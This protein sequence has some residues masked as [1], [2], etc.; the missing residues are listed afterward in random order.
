MGFDTNDPGVN[1][2]QENDLDT[3]FSE[4]NAVYG[5]PVKVGSGTN[6][7]LEQ[8][9]S[10]ADEDGNQR[11]SVD[12]FR[13]ALRDDGGRPRIVAPTGFNLKIR[14][15][16]LSGIDIFDDVGAFGAIN[17]FPSPTAPGTLSLANA[18]LDFQA[19][20]ASA[21]NDS[22]TA[23]PET[24]TEDGFIEVEISG[25]RFQIPAYTP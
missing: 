23:N 8:G 1:T 15:K 20:E 5:N 2:V 25:S 3:P 7:E 11:L 14:A 6:L 16:P 10:L 9:Q 24:D 19:G 4:L 22:M 12:S 17:Y 18:V 13:T 21:T